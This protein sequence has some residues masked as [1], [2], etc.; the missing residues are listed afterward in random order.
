LSASLFSAVWGAISIALLVVVALFLHVPPAAA[1]ISALLLALSS[2]IWIDASIAEIHTMTVALTLGALYAALRYHRSQERR[3]LYW[4]A[5]LSGQMVT[6]QLAS[7]FILPALAFLVL[8]RWRATWAIVRQSAPVLIVLVL[9]GP[10]TYLYLPLRVW[11]GATWVHGNP[12]TWAGLR[13]LIFDSKT[14]LF[15]VPRSADAWIARGDML[16]TVLGADW[17]LPLLALGLLG[18]ITPAWEGRRLEAIALSLAWAPFMALSALIWVDRIGDAV[19]AA[20]LPVIAIAALGV[21]LLAGAIL[22]RSRLLGYAVLLLCLGSAVLLYVRHRPKVLAITRDPQAEEI[23]A[24]ARG[25][26][27]APDGKPVVLTSLEG[28]DY[29]ALAYA[30]AYRGAFPHVRLVRHDA[31]FVGILS[32]GEHLVTL[33]HTFYTW[34]MSDWQD[35]LGGPFAISSFAPQIIEMDTEP[36]VQEADVPAGEAVSLGNGVTV[37]HA[38]LAWSGPDTLVLTVYWQAE[39]DGLADYSIGVHLLARDPPAGPED[40]LLQADRDHPVSGWYHVSWWHAGEI[41]RDHYP[42]Q[43]PPGTTPGA[44]RFNM[45]RARGDGTF[46]NTRWMALPVPAR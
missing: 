17:P 45:Y 7:A 3:D 5:F 10:L 36:P 44:V 41:V 21:A 13:S 30:Q 33:S 14:R 4:L 22:R 20:K 39:R 42:L 1:A 9:L 19:L 8:T 27:P 16:L 29:W 26:A 35:R 25:I 31:D 24:M 37:R 43:V 28:A 15:D 32:R 23:I 2:S 38:S 46:E 11:Q 12:G 6:H 34:P 18:L 40:L